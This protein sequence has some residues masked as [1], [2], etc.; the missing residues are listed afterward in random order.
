MTLPTC[1]GMSNSGLES[2]SPTEVS[3][4]LLNLKFKCSSKFI[5]LRKSHLQTFSSS[6]VIQRKRCPGSVCTTSC[7][8]IFSS[9]GNSHLNKDD[10]NKTSPGSAQSTSLPMMSSNDP[11]LYIKLQ[12]R[13]WKTF[14]L[15]S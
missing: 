4:F 3:L 15:L 14:G 11:K 9:H 13:N 12:S 10:S 6:A 1:F 5:F 2:H 7:D 8:R